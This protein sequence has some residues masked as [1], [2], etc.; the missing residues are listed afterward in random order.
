[1]DKRTQEGSENWWHTHNAYCD[2][3]IKIFLKVYTSG[4]DK[5]SKDALNSM[6]LLQK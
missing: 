1:M 4:P 2:P 6:T 3:K 5:R